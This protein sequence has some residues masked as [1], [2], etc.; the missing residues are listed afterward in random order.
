MTFRFSPTAP[1]PAT[2]TSSGSWNGQPYSIELEGEGVGPEFLI[3][4][5]SLDFGNVQVGTTSA[6]QVVS[7]TN[8]GSSPVVMSGAGG[9]PG[10]P[11]SGAQNCQGVTLDPGA[12]CEMTFRFSPTAPGPAT[13]T[14]SGSWNGQSYSIELEGEGV[15]PEFLITPIGLD[16]GEVQVGT[17]S[18]DQVVSVTN[19]GSSPVVMSGAGGAPGGPFSGFQNCQGVTLDPGA[20]CQVTF[21]FSPTAPG[22]ATATSSGSWNG[23]SYSIELEGAGIGDTEGPMV[24]A[25]TATPN[26]AAVEAS[27]VLSATIDDVARG[28]S[29]IVSAE[30]SR[31]NGPWVPMSPVDLAFDAPTEDVTATISAPAVPGIYELCVRGT[32]S[33]SNVGLPSCI[34]LVVFDPEGGFATGGGWIESPPG[35][36]TDEP[37]LTGRATFGFVSKYRRGATVPE[38]NTQFQFRAAAM[39]FSGSSFEFLVINRGGTSAQ[40]KGRGTINGGIAPNGTEF[41]FMIWATDSDPDTFRIRIWWEDTGTEYTVYDNGAAQPLGGGSIV[42]HT[43]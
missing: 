12:S 9:A 2:A 34:L 1:G 26:P 7:V 21:R 5:T 28:G 35:A 4:R 25:V 33:A 30:Y 31:D 22:P 14:S 39:H 27:V 23:Q 43:R 29:D 36:F 32:D 6:D 37:S 10:G 11:F 42:I 18:A 8:V 15:G 24:T 41:R 16:F 19:V 13:A 17:T 3:T 20:S 40:F 38:G